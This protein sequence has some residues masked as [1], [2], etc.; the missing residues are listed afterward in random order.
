[1]SVEGWGEGGWGEGPYG[2]PPTIAVAADPTNARIIITVT[3]GQVGEALY[4]LRRD[5]SGVGIVRDTSLGTLVW[6]ESS[7]LEVYDYEPRQGDLTDYLL[8]DADGT[9]GATAAITIPAWGTW[10]KSPG[11]PFLNVRCYL[12][13]ELPITRPARRTVVAVEG[14]QTVVVLSEQR[15]GMQGGLRLTALTADTVTAMGVLLDSGLTL[16]LDT[17][18]TWRSPWRY[19]SVGDVTIERAYGD[20]VLSLQTAA[21]VFN[22]ADVLAVEAPIGVTA[23]ASG[24][25]YDTLPTLWGS[26]AALAAT[27]EHYDDLVV[28]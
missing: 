22:L 17:D 4:V 1:M 24:R 7:V 2:D 16:M 28:E 11:R 25:T 27:V 5:T 13:Q 10:L 18:P 23:V 15:A 9:V 20:G 14:S 19:I 3:G 26:Y 12:E 8:T 6:P 21:R